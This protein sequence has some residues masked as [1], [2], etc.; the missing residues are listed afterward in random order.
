M[1]SKD[2]EIYYYSDR[3]LKKVD[4]HTHDYYEFYFFL[5]GDVGIEIE[6]QEYPLRYGD[7]VLI[8]PG[9]RHHSVIHAGQ[10]SRPAYRRFVLWIS[11]EYCSQLM[12]LSSSY[13]YLMQYVLVNR[14]YILHNDTV[15]FNMIQSRVFQLI[16]EVHADRF[17]RE[18]CGP[19]R[20]FPPGRGA[21]AELRGF[22]K[23]GNDV[24]TETWSYQWTAVK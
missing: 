12:E 22:L 3:E 9:L 16:E 23:L 24:L 15:T 5:E 13:G 4:S 21:P 2:F 8:P 10:Q 7:I 14:D 6:A 1:L 11:Q 20:R 19:R 18:A 17:G